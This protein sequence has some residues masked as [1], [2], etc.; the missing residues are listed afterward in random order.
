MRVSGWTPR[1][2][3][4]PLPG[5]VRHLGRVDSV[6]GG[7]TEFAIPVLSGLAQDAERIQLADLAVGHDDSDRG[8][9]LARTAQ[10]LVQ[11]RHFVKVERAPGLEFGDRRPVNLAARSSAWSAGTEW[12]NPQ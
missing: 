11:L 6:V 10:H 1:P 3:G 9:D 5:Q 4:P 8:P 12:A 7:K 2:T